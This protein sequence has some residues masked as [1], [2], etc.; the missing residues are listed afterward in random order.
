MKRNHFIKTVFGASI[1]TTMEGFSSIANALSH[2]NQEH[3]NSSKFASFGAIHL[4]NTNLKKSTIF[5]TKIVGMKLRKSSGTIAKFGTETQTLVVV[6]QTAKTHF[7]KGYSGLYH[8]AIH[9]PN[10]AEFASMINRLLVNNYPFSPVDHTMSKSVY[11]DDPDGINVEFALETPK[12]FKRVVTQGGLRIE[13]S[14]GNIKSASDYLDLNEVMKSLVN[15]DVTKIISDE[16]YIGHLHL[17]A[18]NVEKSNTFYK[19]L[20]FNQ[21]NYLPQFMYADVGAGG[22]YQHRI[23]LN[24]WHGINRP[25]APSDSA[26][27]KHYQINFSTK[28]KLNQA[29]SNVSEYEETD[30][31]YWFHDATGNKILVTC[32]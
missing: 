20:G 14:N 11:L 3:S 2:M 27:M 5:W 30:D 13:D 19:K 25:L 24:S 4:K 6:H 23:A 18:N 21:F 15:K 9:A 10:E 7:K 8:L 12:R 26:G 31:G 16:T 32:S 17:Y 1:L 22:T 29:L 28:E